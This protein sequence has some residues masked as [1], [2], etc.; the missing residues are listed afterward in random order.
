MSVCRLLF[1]N[2]VCASLLLTAAASCSI[3]E[4]RVECPC[5]LSVFPD[6][7]VSERV[8]M[9]VLNSFQ[10]SDLAD[11]RSYYDNGI[12]SEGFPGGTPLKVAVPK[13]VVSVHGVFG[14]GGIKGTGDVLRIR[15]G[16]Q[17]DSVFIYDN[18]M[19]DCTGET[20]RDTLKLAKQW[21]SMR[22][23]F[24]KDEH[25]H[26][27]TCSLEGAWDGF[28]TKTL[29]ATKGSFHFDAEHL[30]DNS[31]A[32]RLPRQGDN[33]LT[34]R[35][36]YEEPGITVEYPLGELIAEARYDWSKANL[37]DLVVFID[38]AEVKVEVVVPGWDKG[39]DYGDVE[40]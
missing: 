28:N 29:R 11:G 18:G 19:I 33:S 4:E 24:K 7:S 5:I 10:V 15:E 31:F 27:S 25:F 17:A 34:L 8:Y 22:I 16:S 13:S 35:I 26:V 20:A 12:V 2:F 37:D 38:R 40:I 23:S 3:K 30:R 6:K 36:E 1:R 39:T 32:A 9:S 21:C 14:S